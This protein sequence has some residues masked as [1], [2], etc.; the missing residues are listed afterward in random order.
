[1]G[2]K[3]TTI[4]MEK[5]IINLAHKETQEVAALSSIAQPLDSL[6]RK[7]DF[8][9]GIGYEGMFVVFRIAEVFSYL[10]IGK[11]ILTQQASYGDIMMFVALIWQLWRPISSLGEMYADWRKNA[12]RH[13][14]LQELLQTP[15]TIPDGEQVY[16][17]HDG[18]IAISDISFSYTEGRSIFSHFALAV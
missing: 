14:S 2:A 8:W 18:S 7:A 4:V 5:Q 6:K 17:Y 1:M 10:W 9:N 12:A 15:V 16:R 13:E 3:E 11:M